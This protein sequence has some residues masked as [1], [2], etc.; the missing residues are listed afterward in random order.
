MPKGPNINQI[1]QEQG[2]EDLQWLHLHILTFL[3]II[4]KSFFSKMRCVRK[5]IIFL[6]I[7]FFY[8][9]AFPLFSPYETFSCH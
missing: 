1:F 4:V 8:L 2:Y 6:H 7:M 5:K 3:K 9:I